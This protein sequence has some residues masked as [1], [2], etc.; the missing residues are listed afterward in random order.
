MSIFAGSERRRGHLGC[1]EMSA[2]AI[3]ACLR[4]GGGPP[5]LPWRAASCRP[6]KLSA[7][8][9]AYIYGPFRPVTPFP[10]GWKPRLHVSQ[11]GR[12]CIFQ[13]RSKGLSENVFLA[14]LLVVVL[15]FVPGFLRFSRTRTTTRT[16]RISRHRAAPTFQPAPVTLH[17]ALVTWHII[18]VT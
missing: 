18:S 9:R 6:E 2:P 14:I 5:G 4:S 1:V 15:V 11:D 16:R 13:A 12:R 3:R 17:M 8:V 10:P 7:R